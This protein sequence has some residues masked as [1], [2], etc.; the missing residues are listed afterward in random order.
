MVSI[1]PSCAFILDDW[2]VDGYRWFQ[3][4]TKLIPRREPIFRKMHFVSVL[5]SGQDKRFKR[6]A[7]FLIDAKQPRKAVLLHYLGDETIVIDF[8]HGNA[9]TDQVFHRTCP[10]VLTD[11]ASIRDH[12]GII[13]K[14]AISSSGCPTEYQPALMPRNSRQVKNIQNRVRQKSRLTQ[15]ALY[16]IHE[17]AYDLDGFVKTITTYPDLVV[18]CGH[19][20]VIRELDSVLH[21]VSDCPQLLSYDTT[22]QLGDFYLSALLFRHT[23]FSNSPVIPALFLVHE[24][25]LEEAHERFMEYLAKLIP[26]L[27]SGKWPVPLVTDEEVGINKV[28]SGS[29]TYINNYK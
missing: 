20:R 12:P 1:T 29:H 18:I 28:S 15:D 17:L 10:S 8:P 14:N 19:D 25:K 16:N 7:F 4:G 27:V 6:Q 23:L 13:Y 5:P 9:K 26:T 21:L 2:R 22:F 24:R 11:L 3:Y